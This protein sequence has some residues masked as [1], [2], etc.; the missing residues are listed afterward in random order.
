MVSTLNAT[1]DITMNVTAMDEGVTKSDNTLTI[2]AGKTATVVVT[3]P[4]AEPYSAKSGTLTINTEGWVGTMTVNFTG[5]TV[6][7][8]AIAVD[9]ADNKRPEGWYVSN[10][11]SG[12]SFTSG[13]AKNSLS[14][15]S[16]ITEKMSVSGADDV[17]TYDAAKSSSWNTSS[18]TVSYSTDRVN[19]TVVSEPELTT[20][21]LAT[22]EVKG[23]AAGEYYLQFKGAYVT[24][25]NII[26][27]HKVTPAPEHDLYMASYTLPVETV[28]PGSEYTATIN[29]AS[30]RANETVT[31]QLWM[32]K[33]EEEATKVAELTEQT[34][35]DGA[36]KAFTLTG[37]VPA[38]EG[39]YKAWAT[40]FNANETTVTTDKVDVIV[41]ETRT[42]EITGFALTS[43]NTAEADANNQFTSTFNVT[44]KNTGTVDL[45]ADQVSVSIVD[46]EGNAYGEATTW[47]AANSQTVFL[48][49]GAYTDGANMAIYRWNT[50]SDQEWALFTEISDGFYSA[51]LNGKSNFIICRVNPETAE[52]DLAWGDN[53]YNQSGN[54]TTAAGNIFG[55]NGYN[56]KTLA[57]T[58]STMA[59]LAKNVSTTLKVTVTTSALEGGEFTFKAKENLSNTISTATALV[60]VTAAAPKFA[61]Y[62]AEDAVADG[63]AIAFGLVKDATTKTFTIKNE[64]NA[65]LELISIVAPDG[66]SAT[67]VTDENKTIA[68]NG[69]LDINIMLNAEQ[70]KVSGDLVFTYKVDASTNKTFTVALSGRS[71]DVDTWSEDFEG[72]DPLA[73]WFN[74]NGWTVYNSDG[75]NVARL[76]GWD[77]KAVITPRLEAAENEILTFDVLSLG[78]AL[79]YAYS[80]DGKTWSDEVVIT[81]TGEQTFTASEAGNYYLRFTG[82]NAYIDNLVGFKLD[83]LTIE[84]SETDGTNVEAGYYATVTLNRTFAAGWNTVCLPFAVTKEVFGTGAKVY[85]FTGYDDSAL[86]FTEVTTKLVAAKPYVVYVANAI[87]DDEPIVLNNIAISETAANEASSTTWNDATFQGTYAPMAA[88]TMTGKYG[89]TTEAKIAKGSDKASMKGFRAYFVLP[90]GAAAR[91]AFFD[92]NGNSTKIGTIAA[93]KAEGQIFNL[94]GQRVE[95]LKKDNLY[96]INGKKVVIK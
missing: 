63:D 45:N 84:L 88:G 70:G 9:F 24:I 43:D 53:V 47:T 6:D 20:T 49:P 25:D 72:T 92:E 30:L 83:P 96:I 89:V 18:L 29:V 69:T 58:Q 68:I 13:N 15:Q 23:L 22:F 21:D 14:E 3:M 87:T 1:G 59:Q 64:G 51:E 57:L 75:N 86:K 27:W 82:R 42:L 90:Q 37:V 56:D 8:S 91:I 19:W 31:A 10:N 17:L 62:Q 44:V 35:N 71:I 40:V 46:A 36:T 4:Y 28:V 11:G 5:S 79:S 34:I 77:A 48:N 80:T 2:P 66:Y 76:T 60:T 61:L 78:N 26:G 74:E 67:N 32:Q 85:D 65:P 41:S 38:T 12:F 54:L 39:S 52:A 50:D 81:T 55:N 95:N 16:M 73:T 94:Q 7:P 33:S 93:E